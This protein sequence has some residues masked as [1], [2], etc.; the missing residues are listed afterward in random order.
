MVDKMTKDECRYNLNKLEDM[1]DDVRDAL[2]KPVKKY[3]TKQYLIRSK[4]LLQEQITAM[5]GILNSL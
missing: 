2:D 1:L 4:Y 3:R 5:R